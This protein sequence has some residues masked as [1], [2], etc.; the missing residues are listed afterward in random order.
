M[1]PFKPTLFSTFILTAG[2]IQLDFPYFTTTNTATNITFIGD[3]SLRNRIVSLTKSTTFSTGS[4]I[5]NKPISLFD[6]LTNNTSSFSTT[7]SFSN[8]NPNNPTS[9]GDGIAF[10]L[11]PNNLSS[12]SSS[13]TTT[14]FGL[15][16]NF[17]AVEFDTR[18]DPRFNDPNG[19]HIGFDID[20]L[21]SMK[22]VDPI[23]N[24]IDLN[25][26]PILI[27]T[28]DLSGYFR[29]ND[30]VYVVFLLKKVLNFIRLKV[31]V[32]TL[33]SLNLQDLGCGVIRFRIILLVYWESGKIIEAVDKRLNGEFED[34]EMR[35]VLML[36]LSCANP[37]NAERPTM[38]RAVPFSVPKVKPSLTFS[39]D[40]PLTIDEIVSNVDD[41]DCEE[42]NTRKSMCEIKI[43]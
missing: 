27:V 20:T 15:S 5:Y 28:V 42:F 16:T 36:G 3:S 31:G 13:I 29:G 1:H 41:G 17:V 43:E 33:L 34:E 19:N 12:S 25:R 2:N 10:F 24:G 26:D 30:G 32:F 37:D 4:I 21:N 8:T 9:F 35:K 6:I 23:Y 7:F 11:S 18:F 14:T 38:R 40:F 39:S 22:T